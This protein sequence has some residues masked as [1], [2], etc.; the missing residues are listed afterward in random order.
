MDENQR[1]HSKW[2]GLKGRVTKLIAKVEDMISADL[3]GISSESI[4]EPRKLMAVTTLAQLRTKRDQ[5]IEL[6]SAIAAKIEAE[7]VFE[8]ETI[9]ADTYQ[10]TLEER[11]A[12]LAEFIRKAGL[13]PPP[14][15]SSPPVLPPTSAADTLSGTT[16]TEPVHVSLSSMHTHDTSATPHAFQ[17]VSRLPKLSLPTF[18]GD[19]LQWQTFW[20]SFNAAVHLNPSLSGVQKFN[21]LR[22]QL[23]GD[24]S[25]VIAGFPLTDHNY[26]HSITLR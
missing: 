7:E 22:A 16:H 17:N 3:E 2:R 24:A 25:R 11:I 13:P 12:F 10:L 5:I 21:Y 14:V 18:S 4:T 8:E 6:D 26:E 1:L 20:D 15:V 23:H 19:S 9:S